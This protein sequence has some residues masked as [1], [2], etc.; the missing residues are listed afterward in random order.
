MA[1][2]TGAGAGGGGGGAAVVV[3]T[4]AGGGGGVVTGVVT[5]GGAFVEVAAPALLVVVGDPVTVLAGNPVAELWV[6]VGEPTGEPAALALATAAA[7]WAVA[8]AMEALIDAEIDDAVALVFWAVEVNAATMRRSLA[9]VALRR[10][11]FCALRALCRETVAGAVVVVV[12]VVGTVAPTK[13]LAS[14]VP[15]MATEVTTAVG[16][17]RRRMVERSNVRE[18]RA[19]LAARR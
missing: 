14:P 11:N 13:A 17:T 3:V 18:V 12:D 9:K 7:A 15:M 5:G 10:A 2:V 19:R 16:R 4:G 1:W 6:E 8:V